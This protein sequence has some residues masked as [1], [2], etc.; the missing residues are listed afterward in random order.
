MTRNLGG[1]EL[2]R[3][4]RQWRRATDQRLAL[5]LDGVQNPFNLGSILRTAAAYSIDHLW[6]VGSPSPNDAKVQKTALGSQKF[7]MTTP[8]DSSAEAITA[9]RS[10][11]Y[12]IIGVELA[13]GATPL[14]ATDLSGDICIV[15][16]HEDRGLSKDLLAG[17]DAIA[18][19][20]QL[21]RIGSLNVATAAA[22]A[23]YEVRRSGWI[24]EI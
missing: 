1:T 8:C 17:A 11:R 12:R 21:G 2:K 13:E 24:P 15:M 22:I 14:H 10:D 3:L 7:V 9:A 23:M 5:M 6:L 4:H 20:P 18:Y 16:G 19:I